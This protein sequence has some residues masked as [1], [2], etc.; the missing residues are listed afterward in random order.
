MAEKSQQEEVK[1]NETAN[2]SEMRNIFQ[3]QKIDIATHTIIENVL[4]YFESKKE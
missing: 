2:L 4:Q 3:Q 1:K